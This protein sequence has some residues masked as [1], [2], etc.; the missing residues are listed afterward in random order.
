MAAGPRKK[1]EPVGMLTVAKRQSHG[2]EEPALKG[3]RRRETRR[4]ST[5]LIVP[6]REIAIDRRN[7]AS[8]RATHD[9]S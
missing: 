1:I 4:H 8:E 9:S 7:P 2:D 6:F 3:D 5:H